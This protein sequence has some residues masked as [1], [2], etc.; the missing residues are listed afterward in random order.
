MK[1]NRIIVVLLLVVVACKTRPSTLASSVPSDAVAL[2][3][4][5][6]KP[7]LTCIQQDQAI[8]K[9]L[10]LSDSAVATWLRFITFNSYARWIAYAAS[11]KIQPLGS[12]AQMQQI[13]GRQTILD[14]TASWFD[15]I[16]ADIPEMKA[17]KSNLATPTRDQVLSGFP[18]AM[19]FTTN[20][21]RADLVVHFGSSPIDPQK[22]VIQEPGTILGQLIPKSAE[23][24]D[25]TWTKGAIIVAGPTAD[26]SYEGFLGPSMVLMHEFGHML[27]VPHVPG[28]VTEP[29]ELADFVL[30]M[31][32]MQG[33][34]TNLKSKVLAGFTSVDLS[35]I[36]MLCESPCSLSGIWLGLAEALTSYSHKQGITSLTYKM[37][38]KYVTGFG[39][40][41]KPP[42]FDSDQ[43]LAQIFRKPKPFDREVYHNYST[44]F[45]QWPYAGTPIQTSV[46][47]LNNDNMLFKIV[48]SCGSQKLPIF[49][50]DRMI[51]GRPMREFNWQE[52]DESKYIDR[53]MD[54]WHCWLG[55]LQKESDIESLRDLLVHQ[56]QMM[57][58]ALNTLFFKNIPWSFISPDKE[59]MVPRNQS[60]C[61]MVLSKLELCIW[62][63]DDIALASLMRNG[64]SY[65]VPL[66]VVSKSGGAEVWG[67]VVEIDSLVQDFK[68]FALRIEL[69]G[70][71]AASR[72]I[73]N[74]TVHV[75]HVAGVVTWVQLGQ[76]ALIRN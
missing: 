58:N 27:G 61:G 7:I 17:V 16:N 49:I 76:P 51:H 25:E 39:A 26:F 36:L 29:D 71:T 13:T 12:L 43:P 5:A 40:N 15:V 48:M 63:K 33:L 23:K 50:S 28:T 53:I 10:G 72:G 59:E 19:G 1:F 18:V 65:T 24:N 3:V 37:I 38:D 31:K 9:S 42:Q 64:Q 30:Q 4:G 57:R 44:V 11:R 56:G 22:S 20:C 68:T 34:S 69:T 35:R 6:D 52:I 66:N 47:T 8:A 45:T 54:F 21:E 32:K 62:R 46:N 75:A 2:F 70:D 55:G 60:W 41:T 74:A 14:S 73:L 67:G